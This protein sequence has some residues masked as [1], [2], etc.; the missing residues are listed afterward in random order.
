M[1]WEAANLEGASTLSIYR[2]YDHVNAIS[3]RALRAMPAEWSTFFDEKGIRKA[4]SDSSEL[5][6][7]WW[8]SEI[9]QLLTGINPAA[10]LTLGL[11]GHSEHSGMQ[12]VDEVEFDLYHRALRKYLK[13]TRIFSK[14]SNSVISRLALRALDKA[15][16]LIFNRKKLN[17]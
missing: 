3:K 13:V 14:S 9:P 7:Y 2:R 5:G 8:D 6:E 1:A 17:L 16:D 11:A 12:G 15:F 4:V 10:V